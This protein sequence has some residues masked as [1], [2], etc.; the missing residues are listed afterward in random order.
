MNE[1]KHLPK[2]KKKRLLGEVE[3]FPNVSKSLRVKDYKRKELIL[4][5]V[6]DM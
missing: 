6:K 1:N 3:V 2:K 4:Y 5:T